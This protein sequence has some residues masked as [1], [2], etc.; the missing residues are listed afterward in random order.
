[1]SS[2]IHH[3]LSVK[4]DK[5]NSESD[6]SS[7]KYARTWSG[8]S[9]KSSSGSESGSGKL[10]RKVVESPGFK[11]LTESDENGKTLKPKYSP[12]KGTTYLPS[13]SSIKIGLA[14]LVLFLTAMG[15]VLGRLKPFYFTEKALF[16]E[17]GAVISSNHTMLINANFRGI[18]GAAG[19]QGKNNK[20]SF[21]RRTASNVQRKSDR[22]NVSQEDARRND[23]GVEKESIDLLERTKS[24][25]V[26]LEDNRK[27]FRVSNFRGRS[28]TK[29]YTTTLY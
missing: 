28:D 7:G 29:N 22:S 12:R 24:D 2:R 3:N 9:D 4:S 13:N 15:I 10:S 21:F 11:K 6:T 16:D 5:S 23:P 1:M 19:S 20:Q 26:S 18:I 27:N 14:T 25:K 17:T 8:K